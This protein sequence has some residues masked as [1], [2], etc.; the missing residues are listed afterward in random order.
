MALTNAINA[1]RERDVLDL[2]TDDLEDSDY[3]RVIK[4]IDDI[5][6]TLIKERKVLKE[7]T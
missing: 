7:S 1:I 2:D 6:K 4:T 3:N 5:T